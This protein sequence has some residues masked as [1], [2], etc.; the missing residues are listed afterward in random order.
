MFMIANNNI[1]IS[2]VI[3]NFNGREFL[4]ICLDSLK[5]QTFLNF[6]IIIVDNGSQDDSLEIIR[7]ISPQTIIYK[8]SQN[9]GFSQAVNKGINLA[10]GKYIFLLNNDTELDN[11]CLKILNDCLDNNPLISFGATQMIFFH[12][13]KIINN[14]GDVFSLYGIANQRGRDEINI[15]QYNKLEPIFGACAG[16]AIYRKSLFNDVG[17]FDEDFFAY[18]EDIDWSFRA[19]IRGYQCWYIPSA[20]VYHIDQGTSR[21]N[22]KLVH[23]L[24][25]RNSLYVIFKNFPN[26]WLVIY[27]PLLLIN[28]IRNILSGLKHGYLPFVFKAYYEFFKN[29]PNL[30]KKRKIIQTNYRVSKKYLASI[31]SKKYPFPIKKNI[32]ELFF[33]HH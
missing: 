9:Q 18:I 5:R 12:N 1:K 3:P 15:N 6:E 8:F 17:L 23:F 4:P 30:Y 33:R 27:S 32:Y 25:I 29:L 7:Q 14:V 10:R 31:I 19:Q 11:D 24:T 20:V 28:Q 26:T 21:L 2:V 16:G 22:K 13:R